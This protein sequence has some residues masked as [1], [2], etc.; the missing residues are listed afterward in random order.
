LAC[1]RAA[2]LHDIDVVH[3]HGAFNLTNTAASLALRTP[4]VFS[5]HSG[6]DPVSLRRSKARKAVYRSLFERRMLRR[7]SLVCALTE[8]ELKHV[9]DY[10]APRP[11]IVIPNGVSR[12]PANVDR[13]AF[14]AKLGLDDTTHVAV[15]LGRLDIYRKGLDLVM[16]GIAQAEGWHL[17][18]VGPDHRGELNELRSLAGN[19]KI[20]HRVSFTGPRHGLE[21]H[22]CLAGADLFALMSRWEGLPMSLLE[23]LS[24]GTPAL[25][26]LEVESLVPVA[27][28]GAGWTASPNTVG[29][30]LRRLAGLDAARMSRHREAA[31]RLSTD[32]DWDAVAAQYEAAYE[33]AIGRPA[34]ESQ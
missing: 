2:T 13:R 18:L 6:Y 12:P 33:R 5:P 20:A 31:L 34:G 23:A 19:L 3:L 26:S 27:A 9:H 4:Y 15:F 11:G 10:G 24:H 32:Y 14:R 16:N 1:A 17:A 25:V 30:T 21:L 22:E 7:A 28:S 29:D 8:V